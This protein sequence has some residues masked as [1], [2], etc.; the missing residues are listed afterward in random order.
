MSPVRV[1]F[2]VTP[3]F[4]GRTGIARYVR[5]LA[6]GFAGTDVE[7][8]RY[9]IGRAQREV[10]PG[11]RHL[12]VPL[13]LVQRS[14]NLGGPPRVERLTGDID[15]VH[16][17]SLIVPRSRRPIVVTVYDTAPL[18][19]PDLHPPRTVRGFAAMMRRLPRAAA[20][21]AVSEAVASDLARHGVDRSRVV[22]TYLGRTAFPDPRPVD[23]AAP[24]LLTVGEQVSR[25]DQAT[26]VQ[27]FAKADLDDVRLVL[28]GPEGIE[29]PRLRQMVADLGV[30]DRVEFLGA[31]D[32]AELAWLYGSALAY[33]FPSVAEGFVTP[34]VEAMGEGL[35]V[36]A[37]EIPPTVEIAGGVALV[38]PVGDVAA[39]AAALERVVHEPGLRDEL[40][41]L[42]RERA[43]RF[44]WAN[45]A[46]QTM[47]AYERALSG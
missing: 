23:V 42:G 27:A 35:P 14:W 41:R 40:A 30:E 39:C 37:S 9:G 44:T 45:T 24:F 6:D 5:Q 25:K 18:D 7:L 4:S 1:A 47:T 10:P 38:H 34:I 12:R 22:V 31:I 29:T 3:V 20:V 21:I 13:R 11:T 19:H 15:V 17:T 2:D 8:R 46:T 32:D 36:V 16:S 43:S 26:L 33:C 28:A